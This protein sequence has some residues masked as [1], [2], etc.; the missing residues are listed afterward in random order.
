MTTRKHTVLMVALAGAVTLPA[1][2]VET[3][4][5]PHASHHPQEAQTNVAGQTQVAAPSRMQ[6]H[7]TMRQRMQEIRATQ[8]PEKRCQLLEAQMSDME[9]MLEAD[10]CPMPSSGMA[11]MR[12]QGMMGRGMMGGGM[13]YGMGGKG[14]H[15]GMSC[16]MGGGG[17]QHGVGGS[18]RPA[19]DDAFMRRL[20]V[21]EKRVDL[22][23][24]LL[25]R[26][27]R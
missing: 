12:Q 5:D 6:R 21:L 10:A 3:A 17:R 4:E 7:L 1:F 25:Q 2:A 20:E 19:G 14:M 24:T 11:E 22:L 26:L 9:A 27:A 15:S 16:G 8:D 23:Q 18:A 13:Q